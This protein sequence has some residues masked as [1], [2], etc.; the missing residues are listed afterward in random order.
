MDGRV[1]PRGLSDKY[2]EKGEGEG[3]TKACTED[4]VRTC[5]DYFRANGIKRSK[6]ATEEVNTKG[7]EIIHQGGLVG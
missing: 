7:R 4:E 1:P 3:G 6:D 2:L 5:D